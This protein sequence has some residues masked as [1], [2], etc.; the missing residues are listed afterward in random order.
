MNIYRIGLRAVVAC[1]MLAACQ[2]P[3]EPKAGVVTKIEWRVNLMRAGSAR[4]IE[5]FSALTQ[6]NAWSA[7]VAK[8]KGLEPDTYECRDLRFNAVVSAEVPPEPPACTAP[9]PADESRTVDC[10]AGTTGSWEQTRTYAATD[11]PACWLAGDWSPTS[12]PDGACVTPPPVPTGSTHV[13]YTDLAYAPVGAFVTVYGFGL[14]AAV[15]G[16]AVVSQSPT[17]TVL[18]WQADGATIGGVAVPV[19]TREGR[20]LEATA[21]NFGSQCNS[22]KPGDV[23]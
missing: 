14:D 19:A 21:S 17:K 7:C 6:E 4:P 11:Y 23:L 1:M 15:T 13:S 10:P 22:L 16:A 20:V 2:T 5:T 3:M 8:L 9:Q 18:R 12:A